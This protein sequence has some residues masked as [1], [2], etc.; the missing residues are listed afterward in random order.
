M[1][2]GVI[3]GIVAG[4][5][6]SPEELNEFTQNVQWNGL[7][8]TAITL[9]TTPIVIGW[10]LLFTVPRKETRATDYL[11]IRKVGVRQVFLWIAAALA[12]GIAWDLFG[13]LIGRPFIPEHMA[14][15]YETAVFIPLFWIAV[16]LVAPISEE[17]LYRGFLF[18][19][20]VDSR[21]GPMGA[22]LIAAIASAALQFPHGPYNVLVIFTVALLLGFARHKSRSIVPCIAMSM[23]WNAYSTTALIVAQTI[24]ATPPLN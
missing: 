6:L 5:R 12:L 23:S 13:F 7:L 2:V 9:V 20:I 3:A 10:L 24:G 19:G 15:M 8:V 22:V 21:L 17:F 18:A 16:V 14:H 4:T 1:I 11:A